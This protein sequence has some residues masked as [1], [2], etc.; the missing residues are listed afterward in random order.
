M[1]KSSKNTACNH[2]WLEAVF[3]SGFIFEV[4]AI[5]DDRA[6]G[7]IHKVNKLVYKFICNIVGR[8]LIC[9]WRT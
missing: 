8:Y 6:I 2:E 4:L 3:F 5:C 7:M 1:N 9:F